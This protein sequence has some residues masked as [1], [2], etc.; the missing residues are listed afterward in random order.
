MQV[1]E[2]YDLCHWIDREIVQEEISQLYAELH[3]V[4]NQNIQP[5]QAKLP[6]EKQ[7][8]KLFNAL[9]LVSLSELPTAQI[10]ILNKIGIAKNVGTDGKKKLENALYIN[11]LDLASAAQVVSESLNSINDG[12]NWSKQM[13]TPLNRI[14]EEEEVESIILESGKVLLRIRFANHA[15][16]SNLSDFKD[17]GKAWWE[18]ARGVTMA[19]GDAPESFEIIGASKG[20]IILSLVTAYA[21]AKTTSGIIME[22]LKVVEKIY[23]IKELAQRVKHLELSNQDAEK[24]VN[25]AATDEKAA[26]L[27]HILNSAIAEIGLDKE[28]QANEIT[29]LTKSIK[30]LVDFLDKGGSVDFVLPDQ[31][32]DEDESLEEERK[33]LESRFQ[34]VRMLEKKLLQLEHQAKE[35]DGIPRED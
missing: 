27:E 2:L 10:E 17:W 18:I 28:K 23:D 19:H 24:V 4:L 13:L 29:E 35:E 30:K 20:S 3:Q 7:R 6:F 5:N 9:E 34:E 11:A 16:I 31:S 15:K 12:V 21:M 26:G 25:K 32:A 33:T 8:D 1:E 22:A 14:V